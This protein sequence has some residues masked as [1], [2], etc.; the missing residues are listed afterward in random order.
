MKWKGDGEMA[1]TSMPILSMSRSRCST[2]VRQT[3]TFSICLRLVARESSFEKRADRLAVRR[4]QVL[5]HLVGGGMWTWQWMSTQ[6]SRRP[7]ARAAG[8]RPG[9]RRRDT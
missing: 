2:D 1:W 9:P 5:D 8:R 7:A 4:H 6:R 3:T